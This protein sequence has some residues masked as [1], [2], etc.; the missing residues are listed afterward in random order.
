M[1]FK[2]DILNAVD[3]ALKGGVICYPTEG[4]YGLG[5]LPEE[6]EAVQRILDF[7]GRKAANGVILIGGSPE[8]LFPWIAPTAA[9][10]DNLFSRTEHPTTWIVTASAIAPY[11]ITGGRN[12]VAV[13]LCEHPV[14]MAL[15]EQADSALVS[16]SANRTGKAPAT[17]A[18]AARYR[19]RDVADAVVGGATLTG[20]GPSAIR[21]GSDG[22]V[23]R[24][25]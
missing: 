5:C 9:E 15:C 19:M 18:V 7:K 16:T 4:V 1:R 14:A 24:P 25:V 21:L 11:W 20:C 6:P 8:H 2:K 13:R 22:T 17:S 23:I 3:V 10:I 12:T